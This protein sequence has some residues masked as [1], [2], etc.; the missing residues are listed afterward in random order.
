[1][2]KTLFHSTEKNNELGAVFSVGAEYKIFPQLAIGANAKY[3][4]DSYANTA[5]IN[6]GSTYYF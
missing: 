2:S 3:Q 5:S 6:V 1:M 4:L